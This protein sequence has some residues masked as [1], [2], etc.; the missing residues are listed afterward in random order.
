MITWAILGEVGH[1]EGLGA[2]EALHGHVGGDG[3]TQGEGVDGLGVEVGH[4]AG[5]G[6]L[7]ALHG[8]V[9]GDG[10]PKGEGGDGLG[11]EVED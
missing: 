5:L 8:H 4:V 9:G 6:A 11:G 3:G 7:E 10:W 2:I 1:V